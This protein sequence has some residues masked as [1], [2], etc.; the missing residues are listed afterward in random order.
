MDT[1]VV[2][3]STRAELLGARVAEEEAARA[4]NALKSEL[5]RAR[6]RIAQLERNLLTA[7]RDS[8]QNYRR[9]EEAERRLAECAD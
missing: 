1:S 6:R 3:L 7:M 9:A 2:E 4:E 8:V 5:R